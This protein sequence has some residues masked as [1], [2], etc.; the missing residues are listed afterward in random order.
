MS[1][2]LDPIMLALVQNRL[3]H[4]SRQMGWVMTRTARSP[5]FS[6]AHDFSCFIADASGNVMS[7]A[8]GLPIHTGGGGFAVRAILRDFKHA[9]APGDVFLLSDPYT[10]GGNHLPDWVIA[11]PVFVTGRLVAFACNRA[12]QIDIGGGAAGTYNPLATE[13]F[14]EGIRLPVLK[15]IEAG[16][17]RE[18]LWRLLLLNTRLP[19]A[20]DG[21]VRAMIGSTRIGAERIALLVE[22]VGADRGGELFE[23]VLDHADRRFRASVSRLPKGSWK[24][25]E[26]MDHDCFKPTDSVIALTLTVSE[27]GLI[28]DFEGTSPQMRG[29][30]NSSVANTT[31]AVYMGLASFFEPDLPKNEGTFRSI[32][33]RLPEGTLVNAR[34]PAP[35]GANTGSPAYE[36]IQAVWKALAQALPGRASAG[37][38]KGVQVIISGLRPNGDRY[39]MHNFAAYGGSGAIEGRDGIN[40]VGPLVTLSGLTFPNLED[41]EQLYPVRF[42]RQEFRCDGGGPGRFRGGT[43]CDY[44]VEVFTPA[45]YSCVIYGIPGV[46]A[47]FGV[48]GGKPGST[49]TPT[50]TLA[51]GT[52]IHPT[53]SGVERYGPATY[54]VLAPGGGGYGDP[55]TRDPSGVLR[56]VRDGIVSVAAAEREYAVA[57]APDGS[58][59][60]EART[61]QLR[62]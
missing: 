24:A 35:M 10:A 7:Q 43:G 38:M 34:L 2:T 18:D 42:H 21:D 17:T 40:M 48:G 37:W 33:I 30:K 4:I 23:A 59:I 12:H 25:E 50:F 1:V 6:Q 13:I 14:H 11:W 51:D 32:E 15:L 28:V 22:E 9:I 45:D 60:D 39:V 52:K 47:S 29:F 57:I 46:S 55:K 54:H 61:L 5:H 49:V 20:L 62:N 8:D 56:D 16:R 26:P 3:D 41:Y 31:S 53:N 58:G 36:I 19:E 44:E 27:S